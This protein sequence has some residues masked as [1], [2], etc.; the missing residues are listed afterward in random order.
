MTVDSPARPRPLASAVRGV[1][2]G[3]LL[4]VALHAGYVLGGSNFRTVLP[5]EVYRCSQPA[6]P[7][8]ERLIGRHSIR[9]VVN[10]RGTCPSGDWYRDEARATARLDVSQEDVS[11]SATR[12]PSTVSIRQLLDVLDRSEY[13]I[14]LHCHQG[15]DRTG[16]ASVM[17]LLLRTGATVAEARRH[18]GV[19]GGH[20]A[21]GKT[22]YMDR[23]F[24]LYESWLAGLGE[25]HSPDLF[26]AWVRGHYCP[27]D[28]KATF[29]LRE[30][31][32]AREGARPLLRLPA[33]RRR[34]LEVRCRNDSPE[35]WR[36]R[37]GGNAGVHLWWTV[38]DRDERVV[39]GDRAGLF[40]AAVA[41][42]G[43]I[44]LTLALPPL[45]PGRYELRVDLANEQHGFFA[46]LGNDP[47]VIEL[48]VT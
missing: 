42:G 31:P 18:L 6:G 21:I 3:L 4:A 2:A 13:P 38:L 32:L 8:L 14:L 33:N 19:R 35:E 47:Y 28:G 24:D 12:L 15:A 41:P 36:F 10:L 37:P 23:F 7:L 5:G 22:R 44:D 27:G 30:P 48:E 46:Q 9:T 20:L 11:L 40:H 39:H 45:S 1:V 17:V 26:R 43:H 29:A 16:L 25:E 34:L